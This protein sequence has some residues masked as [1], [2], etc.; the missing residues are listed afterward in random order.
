MVYKLRNFCLDGSAWINFGKLLKGNEYPISYRGRTGSE[1]DSEV[2]IISGAESK[3]Y[4]HSPGNS[5]TKQERQHTKREGEG[6][7]AK[8]R[9]RKK[10]KTILQ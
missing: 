9:M 7:V 5:Y 8:L 4:M 3:D 1:L 6:E 10:F 2:G